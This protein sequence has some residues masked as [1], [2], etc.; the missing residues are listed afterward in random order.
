MSL[1]VIRDARRD[2]G[3]YLNLGDA[4]GNLLVDPPLLAP[5]SFLFDSYCDG[6]VDI[7]DQ[8]SPGDLLGRNNFS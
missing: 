4:L 1:E 8:F 2:V 6:G 5:Q 7:A 3:W